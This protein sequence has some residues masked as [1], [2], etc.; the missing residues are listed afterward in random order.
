MKITNSSDLSNIKQ[1][2]IPRF[3][4][5]VLTQISA[6]LNAGATFQD[7]F[8]A[9]IQS[10]VFPTANSE[11]PLRHS[12]GRVPSGY[13]PLTLSAAMILYNGST[14]NS[15]SAIYLKSS[16]IGTATVLVF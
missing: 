14:G 2:D 3:L 4:S 1:E 7:N 10:V 6:I 5:A 9:Q 15:D 8:N 16:A 12:L 11:V 13:L